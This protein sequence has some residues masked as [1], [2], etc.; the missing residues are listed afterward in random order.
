MSGLTAFR[1]GATPAPEPTVYPG[2][3]A[4]TAQDARD[5]CQGNVVA[6]ITRTATST[7]SLVDAIQ[8][9]KALAIAALQCP[10]FGASYTTTPADF[11]IKCG[12]GKTGAAVTRSST[13]GLSQAQA[14]AQA[15]QAAI[16]AITCPLPIAYIGAFSSSQPSEAQVLASRVENW[17]RGPRVLHIDCNDRI[18]GW[19]EPKAQGVRATISDG[20]GFDITSSVTRS[21]IVLE[22]VDYW[23]YLHNLS[24]FDNDFI[25]Q[26]PAAS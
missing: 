5:K 19:A 1:C 16:D 20:N 4:T 18:P 2:S 12:A 9:A 17:D 6:S 11:E 10:V 3:Y 22:G 14:L 24:Q 15:K 23:L 7:V 21:T 26:L 8:K 13:S 25:F